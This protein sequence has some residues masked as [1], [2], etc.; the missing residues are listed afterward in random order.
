MSES[1]V[2]LNTS[3][4]WQ[5]SVSLWAPAM[6]ESLVCLSTSNVWKP[7]TP[8]S[9]SSVWRPGVWAPAVPEGLMLLRTP[10]VPESLACYSTSNVWRPTSVAHNTWSHPTTQWKLT[11]SCHYTHRKAYERVEVLLHWFLIL[12]LDI[13]EWSFMHRSKCAVS[14]FRNFYKEEKVARYMKRKKCFK[15]DK[16]AVQSTGTAVL[17]QVRL[18]GVSTHSYLWSTIFR[19]TVRVL[20]L[21]FQLAWL[22]ALQYDIGSKRNKHPVSSGLQNRDVT[23][24]QTQTAGLQRQF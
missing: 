13:S 8:Q 9:T 15:C 24:K 17:S 16:T 3:S 11:Q 10:T 21:G 22:L 1:L 18:F 4:V 5:P 12:A 20:E 23:W 14:S 19:H 7:S 6:S 2:R